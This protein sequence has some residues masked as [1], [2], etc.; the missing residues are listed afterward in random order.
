[1][2]S[3]DSRGG[4]QERAA[5]DDCAGPP[6]FGEPEGDLGE[7]MS[8]GDPD[9]MKSRRLSA[10]CQTCVFRPGNRMHLREG[11]LT[12]LQGSGSLLCPYRWLG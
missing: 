2:T 5:A 8:V 11:R 12:D 10:M 4:H 3:N 1:M 9:V 7:D 6:V